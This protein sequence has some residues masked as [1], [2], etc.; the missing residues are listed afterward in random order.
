MMATGTAT[1]DGSTTIIVGTV[2]GIAIGANITS[3]IGIA[4]RIESH[5]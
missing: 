3:T 4:T 2:T 1:A 5:T